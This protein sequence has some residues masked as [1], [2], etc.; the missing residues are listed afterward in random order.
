MACDRVILGF[1]TLHPFLFLSSELLN[2]DRESER[3][4]IISR[5]G[6]NQGQSAGFLDMKE[7]M[8]CW[9]QVV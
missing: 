7:N 1:L 9:E 5:D 2:V 4:G 3:S 8:R 6:D